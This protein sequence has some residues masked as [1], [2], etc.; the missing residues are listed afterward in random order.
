[1]TKPITFEEMTPTQLHGILSI[2]PEEVE[3]DPGL[4]DLIRDAQNEVLRR[5]NNINHKL[6][7]ISF[8]DA[9]K[10]TDEQL[11]DVLTY[12]F[13]NEMQESTILSVLKSRGFTIESVGG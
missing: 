7:N 10:F 2:H 13:N 3:K 1:M 12:G 4:K 8:A 9:N 11:L 5:R 6:D